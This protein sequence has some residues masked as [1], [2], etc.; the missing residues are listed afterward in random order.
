MFPMYNPE[1]VRAEQSY[2]TFRTSRTGYP[3]DCAGCV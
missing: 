3:V 2:L 1:F